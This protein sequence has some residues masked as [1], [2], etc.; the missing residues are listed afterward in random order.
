MSQ[1]T[2]FSETVWVND[3]TAR[4]SRNGA[5]SLQVREIGPDLV[6]EADVRERAFVATSVPDWPG[7]HARSGALAIPLQ[8]VNHA[9]VGFW[10]PP[11]RHL[12]R[13]HYLPD[14]FLLGVALAAGA[15]LVALLAGLPRRRR[16][17]R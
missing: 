12:V 10:L 16:A 2:D 17:I 7:W 1:A 15:A 9:F 6:I 8:T 11:G 13:L 4:D 3:G 14:S 5:A